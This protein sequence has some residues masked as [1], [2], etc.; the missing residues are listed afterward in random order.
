MTPQQ[1]KQIQIRVG[2][3]TLVGLVLIGAMVTYFGRLGDGLKSY[4]QIRVEYPNASGLLKG[5]DVLMAGAKIGSVANGPFILPSG[6]GVYVNLKIYDQVEIPMNSRFTIGSSGLL[7]DRFVDITMPPKSEQEAAMKPMQT[8]EGLPESG[9][10]Q[11]AVEGGAMIADIRKAVQTVNTTVKRIDEQL[12]TE[13]TLRGVG[14]T[15]SNLKETSESLTQSAKKLDGLISET[16]GKIDSVLGEA[17]GAVA[18]GKVAMTAATAAAKE[19]QVTVADFRKIAQEARKGKGLIGL[20]LNDEEA[21]N[22][23]RALL[24]NLRAKGILFYKDKEPERTTKP[25]PYR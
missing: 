2:I 17:K 8:V 22:N 3:F 20:M 24:A 5:A 21:A 15:I 1:E 14:T 25:I 4:Y 10:S 19:V 11:L 7:G 6:M 12:L 23:V 13:Q 9:F 16:G 18:E